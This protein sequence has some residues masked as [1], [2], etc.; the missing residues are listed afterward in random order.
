MEKISLYRTAAK[1][2]WAEIE[3]L[4]H[5]IRVTVYNGS[6]ENCKKDVIVLAPSEASELAKTINVILDNYV[7]N[8][9]NKK[10]KR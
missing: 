7:F 1:L 9:S 4:E 10:T 2:P 8:Y 3:T 5:N 6:E